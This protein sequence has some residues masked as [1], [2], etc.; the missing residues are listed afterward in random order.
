MCC[1]LLGLLIPASASA[2]ITRLFTLKSHKATITSSCQTITVYQQTY[3]HPD[4]LAAV[5]RATSDQSLQLR[6]AWGTPCVT[7][8]AGGWPLFLQSGETRAANGTVTAQ[9]GGEHYWNGSEPFA[10]VTTGDLTYQ[11]WA[12]AFTHE[13]IEAVKNPRCNLYINGVFGEIADPVQNFTY[14]LDGVQVSDFV[15]P[16]FY[17][18]DNHAGPWDQAHLLTGPV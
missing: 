5:E 6:S 13:V 1:I 9:L 17:N 10:V 2:H 11:Y 4:A 15:L 16:T 3:V 7:F 14:A 12:R 8:G 18:V